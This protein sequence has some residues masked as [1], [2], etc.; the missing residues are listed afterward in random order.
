VHQ[1]RVRVVVD[2]DIYRPSRCKLYPGRST[3]AAGEVV[4]DDLVEYVY[5]P[6]AHFLASLSFLCYPQIEVIFV[7]IETV[8]AWESLAH[9]LREDDYHIFVMQ[10][11]ASQSEGFRVTFAAKG[12]KDVLVVTHNPDVERVIV[13]F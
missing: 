11:G 2:C 3:S 9:D 10:Y 13:G 5:L 1:D 8:N 6:A 4:N 7:D 12:Q